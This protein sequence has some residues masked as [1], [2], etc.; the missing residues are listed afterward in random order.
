[1]ITHF[2]LRIFKD[3]EGKR[4]IPFTGL[5]KPTIN[6]VYNT[7]DKYSGNYIDDSQYREVKIDD[8]GLVGL[9]EVISQIQE[10]K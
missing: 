1:M 8:D 6:F 9:S 4:R 10:G 2:E 7:R 3:E 5:Q